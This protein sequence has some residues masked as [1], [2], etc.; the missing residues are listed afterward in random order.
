MSLSELFELQR[1]A[2]KL[3]V[4][5]EYLRSLREKW[6]QNPEW[7]AHNKAYNSKRWHE[8]KKG[9]PL[10][11][12][13]RAKANE[14]ARI[15]WRTDGEFR[16]KKVAYRLELG[17]Q[18]KQKAKRSVYRKKMRDTSPYHRFVNSARSRIWASLKE[19]GRRKW[20]SVSELVG[21]TREQMITHIESQ[22]E[23]GMTWSNN[24][25][26]AGKWHI[27]HVKPLASFPLDTV[28][29]QK[30]AFSYLN[31]KPVWSEKNLSKASVYNGKRWR[32]HD[33]MPQ[34]TTSISA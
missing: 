10:T 29:S 12:E 31:T 18:P 15:K 27:D 6:Q 20:A 25:H 11:P 7:V 22:F 26:G 13:A 28:E 24:G 14:R 32:Y 2:D 19:K 33:H 21:G 8:K 4:K 30:E 23:P 5:S 16:K 1:K 17:K 34:P 9:V 3:R